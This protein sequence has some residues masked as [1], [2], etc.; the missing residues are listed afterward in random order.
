VKTLAD[1]RP[2]P[3]ASNNCSIE[4]GLH[5]IHLSST[6]VG[7]G[8]GLGIIKHTYIKDF[9]GVSKKYCMF[10]AIEP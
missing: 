9:I 8:S 1:P 7:S 3:F 4:A 2:I 6:L 5:V 10:F